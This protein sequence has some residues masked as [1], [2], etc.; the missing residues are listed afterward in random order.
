M[1]IAVLV[2]SAFVLKPTISQAQIIETLGYV[3]DVNYK[4]IGICE[5]TW[6]ESTCE[7]TRT[8]NSLIQMVANYIPALQ[9]MAQQL[10]SVA[11]QKTMIVGTFFDAKEQLEAQQDLD[12]LKAQAHKDYSPSHQM[13]QFGSFVKTIAQSEE[14]A[15]LNK[16]GLHT[17]LTDR[18][19]AKAGMASMGGMSA[20]QY[21]RFDVFKAHY[22]DPS[23]HGGKVLDK[24]CP[25]EEGKTLTAKERERRNKDIDFVRT[26]LTPLTLN[27]NFTDTSMSDDELDVVELGKNL[28][29]PVA[30]EN[31][32]VPSADDRS[33]DGSKAAEEYARLRNVIAKHIVAHNS[34]ITQ[35]A[36]KSASN[37]ELGLQSGPAY[38]KA[39]LVEFGLSDDDANKILGENPS[40][41]A[42][43]EVLTK[44]IYQNPDFYTNLYDKPTNVARINAA[45]QA[46]S[47]MNYR[48]R[49]D[50]QLRQEL[51]ISQMVEA[52]LRAPSENA[53]ANALSILPTGFTQ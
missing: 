39:L 35:V 44:K 52:H 49:Y 26:V 28:Y 24:I 7:E 19:T 51:L 37:G 46:I 47:L 2:L 6:R 13:C 30:L 43:M 11:L 16:R 27:I 42:Q 4:K 31:F 10:S 53:S 34:Y 1:M 41:Y 21:G 32:E 5:T 15:K 33:R 48:D 18:Y 45:M 8:E 9:A 40:Y 50:S 25:P 23:D 12:T 29:W 38:M 20:D 36:M 3:D 14:R 22:C 17:T